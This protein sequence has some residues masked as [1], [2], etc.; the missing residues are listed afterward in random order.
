MAV[1]TISREYTRGR[2]GI[3]SFSDRA[4]A[5]SRAGDTVLIGFAGAVATFGLEIETGCVF[6]VCA[7]AILC[8]CAFISAR[9]KPEKLPTFTRFFGLWCTLRFF[10]CAFSSDVAALCG[11][12]VDIRSALGFARSIDEITKGFDLAIGVCDTRSVTC[13]AG[14]AE[15]KHRKKE[16]H[17]PEKKPYFLHHFALVVEPFQGTVHTFSALQVMP[18]GQ[19]P[20]SHGKEHT[21]ILRELALKTRHFDWPP[22]SFSHSVSA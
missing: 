1:S 14:E 5:V 9:V 4:E 11:L 3:T 8:D 13:A 17:I 21:L 16:E 15:R 20:V 10:G 12:T 22:E 2:G 19:L 18:C 6:A 7:F